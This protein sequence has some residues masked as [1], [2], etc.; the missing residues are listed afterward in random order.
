[1]V[2]VLITYSPKSILN[3]KT[4]YSK[5][6]PSAAKEFVLL[7]IDDFWQSRDQP[8]AVKQFI[9]SWLRFVK[10]ISSASHA[11]SL[12]VLLTLIRL[13]QYCFTSRQSLVLVM[14]LLLERASTHFSK[15]WE[16]PPGK[17]RFSVI[18]INLQPSVHTKAWIHP[19]AV[20]PI[21]RFPGKLDSLQLRCL[22][23]RPR[24]KNGVRPYLNFRARDWMTVRRN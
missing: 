22:L 17:G 24:G 16:Q 5:Q 9:S 4:T 12:A 3:T 23:V 7:R 6:E 20:L 8:Q 2:I 11:H 21:V 1:M 15:L 18:I 19:H 14:Y 10:D 13:Q